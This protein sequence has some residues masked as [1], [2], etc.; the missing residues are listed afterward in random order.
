AAAAKVA[1]GA[2]HIEQLTESRILIENGYEPK[3][4]AEDFDFL[5]PPGTFGLE[6]GLLLD[7]AIA[8]FEFTLVVL[9]LALHRRR[10]IWLLT[11]LVFSGFFGY[12]LNR[13]LAGQ[14]CGCF[15]VLWEP[16]KGLT[17][18]L[19]AAFVLGALLLARMRG[20]CPRVVLV[21]GGLSLAS[22]GAGYVYAMQTDPSQTDSVLPDVVKPSAEDAQSVDPVQPQVETRSAG[23]RLVASDFLADI[24]DAGR[25]DPAW[26]IFIWDPTCTTCTMLQPIVEIE[27]MQL[28]DEGSPLL[29]VRQLLKGDI[30]AETGIR[31][32]D[33]DLSPTVLIVQNGS[34]IAEFGDMDTLMPNAVRDN[35]L[36]GEP[37]GSE[38]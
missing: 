1:S 12:A 2:K 24:R 21:A 33:W 20:T 34:I 9:I 27:G 26:Y 29:Q 19:D 16:P 38:P 6:H 23:E 4:T 14:S 7:F 18:V 17:L 8:I 32:F 3:V 37:I 22:V 10:Y 5:V 28:A 36:N 31:E 11:A 30:E 15:G 13:T 25:D 35:L